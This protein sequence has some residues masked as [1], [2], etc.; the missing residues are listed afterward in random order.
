[1]SLG[2]QLLKVVLREGGKANM[3]KL[4]EILFL[5]PELPAYIFIKNHYDRHSQLPNEQVLIDNRINIGTEIPTEPLEYYLDKVYDR[6]KYNNVKE[7]VMRI[8]SIDH[9]LEDIDHVAGV[10]RAILDGIMDVG[11]GNQRITTLAEAWSVLPDEYLETQNST[12]LR[13]IVSGYECLDEWTGGFVA[14]DV[15]TIAARPSIG[16]S[17]SLL[18]MALKAWQA[19]HKVVFVT[20]EM[21]IISMVKRIASMLVPLNPN[22]FKHGNMSMHKLQNMRDEL[23]SIL[24]GAGFYFVEGDID[25]SIEDIDNIVQEYDPEILYI[26]AAYLVHSEATKKGASKWEVIDEVGKK[27]KGIAGNR[28]IPVVQSV[29]LNRTLKKNEEPDLYHIAG[30]D[31]IGQI[32]TIVIAITAGKGVGEARRRKYTVIKNREGDTGFWISKFD[33]DPIDF[34]VVKVNEE[35]VV[36]QSTRYNSDTEVITE[37]DS[38][39]LF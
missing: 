14:G 15:V 29:Q 38:D 27:I 16:K 20:M 10:A 6:A 33:F 28:G 22:V 4:K 3:G 34:G 9:A 21:T 7:L 24:D 35:E 26:D 1:M 30:G 2:L 31:T 12:G 11:S 39:D 18:Y 17:W 5:E 19:G 25:R 8:G 36:E 23:V 13:G 37:S 32:S